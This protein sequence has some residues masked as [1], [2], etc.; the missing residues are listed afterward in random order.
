MRV[1]RADRFLAKS[2]LAFFH[3]LPE[4]PASA[5]VL[6]P[7][8][9]RLKPMVAS[10][11]K[12]GLLQPPP[13]TNYPAYLFTHSPLPR[14]EG[15]GQL[16]SCGPTGIDEI[17]LMGWA[18]AHSRTREANAVLLTYEQAGGEPR[19]FGL[20]AQRVSR[21]DLASRYGKDPYFYSGWQKICRL[22]ELPKGQMVIRAWSYDVER[23]RALPL[24]GTA[25]L[26]NK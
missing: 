3:V 16:E 13:F 11:E 17:L 8:Y 18:L 1:V 20:V 23:Q 22:S 25:P 4:Q 2:C 5:A 15:L 26:E 7:H 21:P 9:E 6:Y 10:L 24:E 12:Q 19:L 14:D